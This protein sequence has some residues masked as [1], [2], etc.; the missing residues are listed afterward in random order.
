MVVG[1][2]GIP[3]SGCLIIIMDPSGFADN[4]FK[5]PLVCLRLVPP[6]LGPGCPWLL[7]GKI[8]RYVINE[9]LQTPTLSV[10]YIIII[11]RAS[12]FA[13]QRCTCTAQRA[14][15]FHPSITCQP[16][17]RDRLTLPPLSYHFG[18]ASSILLFVSPFVASD[19]LSLL[20]LLIFAISRM[21]P[22]LISGRL[23]SLVIA[24]LN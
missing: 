10:D 3:V 21:L 14:A 8:W 16:T 1:H 24:S 7:G 15:S 22:V 9:T 13:Y 18:T 6:R 12:P 20:F 2:S 23:G 11:L 4:N 19:P 5:P 17:L